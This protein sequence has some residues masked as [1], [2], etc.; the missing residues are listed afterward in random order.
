M[1]SL[2]LQATPNL[3]LVVPPSAKIQC[4]PFFLFLSF[5]ALSTAPLNLVLVVPKSM[6]PSLSLSLQ[7]TDLF[8]Q[9]RISYNSLTKVLIAL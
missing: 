8:M 3:R 4:S 1:C 5:L 7:H 2:I 9:P 6:F